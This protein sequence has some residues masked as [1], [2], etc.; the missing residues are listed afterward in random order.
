M[1]EVILSDFNRLEEETKAAEEQSQKEYDEFMA[2]S[3]AD[4]AAKTKDMEHKT[5]KKQDQEQALEERK[6]DLQGTKEE[7]QA[8]LEYYDKLKP[9]CIEVGV[10]YEERVAKRKEEIESLQQALQILE[11]T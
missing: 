1:L 10:S 11:G 5:V 6:T 4:K 7:L 2:D 3:E 8:A 9:A